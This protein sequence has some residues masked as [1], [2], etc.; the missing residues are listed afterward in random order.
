MAI[1]VDRITVGQPTLNAITLGAGGSLTVGIAYYYRV[2]A[3]RSYAGRY[4]LGPAS[5]EQSVTPTSGNQTAQLSWAAVPNATAYIL[6]RTTTSGSYP[7]EGANTFYLNGQSYSGYCYATTLTSLNDDGGAATN[8]R[9]NSSNMDFD[10]EHAIIEVYG[11]NITDVATLW[12]IASQVAG[13]GDDVQLLGSANLQAGT[14]WRD[15]GI[16]TLKGHLYARDCTYRQ[17]GLL[18]GLPGSLYIKSDSVIVQ[19]GDASVNYSP[20]YLHMG[21][22]IIPYTSN[23]NT[24]AGMYQGGAAITGKSG[25]SNTVRM[26]LERPLTKDSIGNYA[27]IGYS[28]YT[29]MGDYRYCDLIESVTGLGAG[30]GLSVYCTLNSRNNIFESLKPLGD[31][32]FVD[33]TIRLGDT[34]YM[35]W[36][37]NQ[38]LRRIITRS[39][40]TAD[41]TPWISSQM[42]HSII[43]HTFKAKGQ[44]DN[45]PYGY[46]FKF[47]NDPA[48]VILSVS[49]SFIV[50]DSDGNQVQGA[51]ITVLNAGGLSAFWEDS[52][53]TFST[54]L[55]ASTDPASLTVSD[56]SKFSV[57]DHIRC[58]TYGECL[59]VTNIA[60]NVLTVAR[61][62]LGTAMR[63][64]VTGNNNRVLKM[65]DSL[66]TDANGQAGGDEPILHRELYSVTGS[67]AQANYEDTLITNGYLGRNYYGPYVITISKTGYQDYQAQLLDPDTDKFPLGPAVLEVALLALAGGV[68]P[69][70][71]GLVPLGIKQVAA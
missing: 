57:N 49:R 15:Q 66:I 38:I 71:Q 54:A 18:L 12:E 61:A 51:E 56:G 45:Q 13:V 3:L 9:F 2:I 26:L 40:S 1:N 59:K 65:V 58:E 68:S 39:L 19:L 32:P 37:S 60:G 11:D 42:G 50:M 63:K 22:P 36:A 10:T 17:R 25:Q 8:I 7:V 62:Q 14:Y 67:G 30:G 47:N 43:D 55:D 53:S 48:T 69:I 23:N 46:I 21:M 31:I 29:S 20:V 33:A 34:I 27:A 41:I 24:Y 5:A 28:K 16:Y 44:T 6:Q 4:A 52:L 35:Q 64:H 70:N